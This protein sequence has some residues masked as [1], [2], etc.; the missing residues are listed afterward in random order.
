MTRETNIDARVTI[1][2]TQHVTDLSGK[3]TLSRRT[4]YEGEG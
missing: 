2:T 4:R 3:E 1:V